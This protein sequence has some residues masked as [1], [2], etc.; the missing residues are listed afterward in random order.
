VGVGEQKGRIG[1]PCADYEVQVREGWCSG[2]RMRRSVIWRGE[3]ASLDEIHHT[4]ISESNFVCSE[5]RSI[6]ALQRY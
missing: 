1:E 5:H 2:S 3:A 6:K 4:R